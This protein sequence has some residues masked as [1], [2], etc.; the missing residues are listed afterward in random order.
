MGDDSIYNQCTKM[1]DKAN[2]LYLAT[3]S[4]WF[5]NGTTSDVNVFA[6][7]AWVG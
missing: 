4:W 1:A 7:D 3:H 6:L 5:S 2:T